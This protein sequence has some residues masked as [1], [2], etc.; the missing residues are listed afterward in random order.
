MHILSQA[1]N[2]P[3]RYRRFLPVV[4]VQHHK[5]FLVAGFAVY[6]NTYCPRLGLGLSSYATLQHC[7]YNDW[8]MMCWKGFGRK[9]S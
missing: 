4:T 2:F 1:S 9:H 7:Q 3:T 8:W 6:N 5:G